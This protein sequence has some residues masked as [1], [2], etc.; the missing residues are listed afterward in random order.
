MIVAVRSEVEEFSAAV[1][2][3]EASFEPL[4]GETVSQ[5]WLLLTVQLTL[6]VIPNDC[7][8]PES[9]KLNEVTDTVRFAAASFC[10]TLMVCVISP[11]ATVIVAVRWEVEVLAEAVTVIVASSEPLVG[12]TVSHDDASPATVQFVFDE[13]ENVRSSPE[14]AK[15][16]EVTDTVR[17]EATSACVTFIVC[18]IP[19]PATVIVAVRW[20]V[21]VFA[22]AVTV[23]VALLEPLVGET[24]SHDALLLIAQLVLDEMLNVFC[25]PVASK[26]SEESDKDRVVTI[27]SSG[28]LLQSE[29]INGINK[30]IISLEINE[31]VFMLNN[32]F[33]IKLFFTLI[34]DI[35]VCF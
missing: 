7:S 26:L 9:A 14:A 27:S 8:S 17:D 23:T 21:E 29:I 4:V 22:A 19:P 24:V 12:E 1:T 11:P 13:M 30:T 2:V 10:V 25:S 5:D 31:N 15:L 16:N 3:T 18:V 20:E 32:K 28:L 33:F 35:R 6:D 34:K